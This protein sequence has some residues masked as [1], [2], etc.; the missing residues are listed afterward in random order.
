MLDSGFDC[1]HQKINTTNQT[2][3]TNP[4]IKQSKNIFFKNPLSDK[5]IMIDN[6]FI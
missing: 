4:K 3:A 6:T 5:G 1:Q 2:T